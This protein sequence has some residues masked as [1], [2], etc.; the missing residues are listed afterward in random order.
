MDPL[1]QIFHPIRQAVLPQPSNVVE[2]QDVKQ[3][4][5]Y[6]FLMIV[7]VMVI[8]CCTAIGVSAFIFQAFNFILTQINSALH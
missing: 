6:L 8:C 4:R 1:K 7:G 3:H 2:M 5:R